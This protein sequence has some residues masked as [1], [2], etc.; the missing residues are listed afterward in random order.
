MTARQLRLRY[1]VFIVSVVATLLA[2]QAIVQYDISLQ[3]RDARLINLAGRQRMLSQ[4]I[5]KL[6]LFVYYRANVEDVGG[7]YRLDTLRA[8][9]DQWSRVHEQLL[10]ENG[11]N[12]GSESIATLLATNTPRVQQIRTAVDSI[13]ADGRPEN[14]RQ[15]IRQIAEVELPYLLTM[16]QTVNEFQREAER[17]IRYLKRVEWTLAAVAIALLLLE[18]MYIFRPTLQ[19]LALQNEALV[20]ANHSLNASH[21]KLEESLTHVQALREMLARNERQ[22]RDLVNNALDFIYELDG[23]GKFTFVNARIESDLGY[24]RERLLQKHYSEIIHPDDR[25]EQQRFYQQQRQEVTESSYREFRVVDTYGRARWVGQNVRMQ[26]VGK[27]LYR[28]IAIARDIS[29]SKQ[30]DDALAAHEK[31]FRLIS[32]NTRDVISLHDLEGRFLYVSPSSVHLH[33]YPASEMVGKLATDFMHPDD[34]TRIEKHVP[35]MMEK[36][37]KREPV[38]PIVFRV[39]TRHRGFVWAENV[40]EP[41]FTEDA[42]TGFQS[43]VRDISFREAFNRA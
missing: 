19:R 31:L 2:S 43:V 36:M 7:Y 34:V 38:P 21:Q 10:F 16:E 13:L 25:A 3:N 26:F 11:Q 28:V 41:V 24:S 17:K 15:M 5:S 6:T 14:V 30:A 29:R 4:R 8:L 27:Q 32:E 40:V 20:N 37:K 9:V 35:E 12:R 23:Q 22:Y 18:F 33:G 42:L 1:V 39:A